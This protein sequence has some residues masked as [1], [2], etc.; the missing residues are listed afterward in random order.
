VLVLS[1]K[2]GEAIRIGGTLMVRV[3]SV[4]GGRVRLAIDAP[5]DVP[6]HRE[7]I[8][9]RIAD[10]N[11]AAACTEQTELGALLEIE[12]RSDRPGGGTRWNA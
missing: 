11:Q 8:I 7:E 10:A 4:S 2:P 5:A 12:P 9:E 3:V 1:R 6:V